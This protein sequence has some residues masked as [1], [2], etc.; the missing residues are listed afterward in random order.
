MSEKLILIECWTCGT[1][2]K[3][4]YIGDYTHRQECGKCQA[5]RAE[6]YEILKQNRQKAEISNEKE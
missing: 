3:V 6:R 4:E 5:W 1:L 2:I